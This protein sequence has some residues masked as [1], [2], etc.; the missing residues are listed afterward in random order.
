MAAESWAFPRGRTRFVPITLGAN[1]DGIRW[2]RAAVS[3]AV[4]S[5]HPSWQ[6]AISASGNSSWCLLYCT[7]RMREVASVVVPDI[8]VTVRI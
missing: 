7:I 8:A 1:H 4:P 3:P 5:S 6:T 2:H